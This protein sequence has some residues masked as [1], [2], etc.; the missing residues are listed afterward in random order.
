[1]SQF[2][3]IRALRQEHMPQIPDSRGS[4]M[5]GLIRCCWSKNSS[6]RPSFQEILNE[7]QTAGFSILPDADGGMMERAVGEILAWEIRSRG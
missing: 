6:D 1:M 3:V 2:D 5:Q 7:F 4:L